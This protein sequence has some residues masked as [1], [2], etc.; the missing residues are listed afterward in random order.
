[1]LYPI[2]N[3]RGIALI[4]ALMIM[5]MLII[6]GLGIVKSSNDE[7]TI[8]GNELNEMRA[9][10]AAES[11]L[12]K[13]TAAIQAHYEA[14]GIP[15]S[16]FPAETLLFAGVAFGYSTVPEAP[17]IKTITKTALAGLE[18][19]VRPYHIS[20]TAVDSSHSTA[21][22]LEQHF[23]VAFVPIFQFG[24]F[25]NS[26]LEIAPGTVFGPLYRIH[27]NSDVY[28][29]SSLP[30]QIESYVT[31][32]GN[33][34]HGPK[35]GSGMAETAGDVLIMGGDKNFHSMKD[36][37]DWLDATVPYWYDS[38]ASRWDGRVQDATFK[39]EPLSLP[40]TVGS[41]MDHQLI[42]R[43]NA[44]TNP[45]SIEIK[46]SFKF[47]DGRAYY[48]IG[49]GTW[50]DITSSLTSAGVIS[51]TAFHDKRE[52]NEI[53]VIDF[54]FNALKLT[55]YIPTN[56]IVYF[57]D[58]RPGLR[59]LRLRNASDIGMPL[60]IASRNPVYT[61]GDVNTINKRPVAIIADA[62]TVLSGNWSDVPGKAASALVSH[63]PAINTTLNL[64]FVAGHMA[65]GSG[66]S[67]YSG[68]LENVIRL[69]EDWG[70]RTLTFRG[71][72]TSL[73]YSRVAVGN[74]SPS[75]FVP[76]ARDWAWDPELSDAN[77]M[78]PATP[79]V[80]AFI[81]WGWKQKD[82][83]YVPSEFATLLSSETAP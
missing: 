22:T 24:A 34:Y 32:V 25:Y 53:T 10:Y 77:A 7:I 1:M 26:D 48:D 28:V 16:S 14:T 5:L 38:A 63:R 15:P 81:R 58:S 45:Y 72:M 3:E 17:E 57:S 8:A 82:V 78:P 64:S 44:T 66:T 12:E 51:E 67:A 11:G 41:G 60:T 83:G 30:L 27:C 79:A 23:E 71:S 50:A 74:W 75:Y 65:T 37:T 35:T 47:I 19:F 40:F 36:G 61:V 20:S 55:T 68:G 70:G 69:L 31:A 52:N 73:W 80:R 54:D 46:S 21:V 33:I 4:I 39:I 62:L 49:G 18:A 43:Y 42:D 76:P 13:G 56:G 6:I 2:H 9:F 29:Q 59:G